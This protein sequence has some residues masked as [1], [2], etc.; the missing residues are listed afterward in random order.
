MPGSICD[1]LPSVAALLGIPDAPDPLGLREVVGDGVRRVALVLVDGM[2][3][4]L[5]PQLALTS[6]LLAS[7]LGG[8][9]GHLSELSC[10]FPSTTPTNLVSLATGVP[11]GQ[12]GVLGFTVN[13]PG[14][15]RLLNHIAWG[16]EPPPALWQP[17]PTWF[18]RLRDAG[19]TSRAVLPAMFMGSGLTQCTY[20]GAQLWPVGKGQS[21]APRLVAALA[22]PGLTYGYTAVL[23]HAAHASGVG[24]RHWQVAATKVDALL[25]HILDN[26][27]EDAVLVVT[28]D[29]GGI[30]VAGDRRIDLDADPGLRAGIRVVA[31]EPRVRYL[32]TQPG[33]QADVLD[34]WTQRLAGQ[35]LVQTREQAVASGVFGP[36]SD[37]NL[38]RIG[39][40]VVTCTTDTAILASAHEPPQTAELVGLHGGLNPAETAIPLV[41]LR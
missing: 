32:H 37:D 22:S 18:E 40:V 29:H 2:G 33:A 24:S 15:D 21:Y 10:A 8:T 28:A 3:S 25:R 7:V 35:A 17:V 26:L 31:G 13:I 11:P 30:N 4:Y 12:H 20:R 34:A 39:D 5:L 27:P 16:D 38:A 6:P 1:I 14:T 19:V 36:V 9:R 41:V 23:D